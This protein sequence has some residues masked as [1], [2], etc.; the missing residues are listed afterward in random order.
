MTEIKDTRLTILT[1]DEFR[2]EFFTKF[3]DDITDLKYPLVK[4]GQFR[5]RREDNTQGER[6]F[7]S[8]VRESELPLNAIVLHDDYDLKV[9]RKFEVI[10]NYTNDRIEVY[11]FAHYGDIHPTHALD[12]SATGIKIIDKSL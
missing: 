4:M 8:D 1:S 2:M 3:P 12:I 5:V 10:P 9:M 11:R 7:V 6:Y